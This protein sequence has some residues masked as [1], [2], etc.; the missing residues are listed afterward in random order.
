VVEENLNTMDMVWHYGRARLVFR[1]CM[2]RDGV[3]DY[4]RFM[5]AANKWLISMRSALDHF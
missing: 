5:R 3:V 2:A 1:K 4:A